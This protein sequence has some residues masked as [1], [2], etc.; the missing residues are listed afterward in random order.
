[1]DNV[2][3]DQCINGTTE[4]RARKSLDT[5]I[6]SDVN[7]QNRIIMLKSMLR[8]DSATLEKSPSADEKENLS[9]LPSAMSTLAYIIQCINLCEQRNIA[10]HF[11]KIT[12]YIHLKNL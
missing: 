6:L 1:M 9:N 12:W 4:S 2:Y 11:Q 3:E 8:A 5:F 7:I 10:W